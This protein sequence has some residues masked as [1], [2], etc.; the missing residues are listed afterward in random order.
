M[1]KIVN[2]SRTIVGVLFIFSG[3]VKANDPQGL[4]Y[5]MQEFFEVWASSGFFKNL[6]LQLHHNALLF[7]VIMIAAEIVLG[8][9]LLIAWKPKLTTWLLFLLTVF[10]TFLTAYVLFSGKIKACGCFGDCIPLTPKQ[11]FAKDIVLLVLVMILLFFQKYLQPLFKP[12]V[13]NIAVLASLAVAL[14]FQWYCLQYLPFKDCLPYKVGNDIKVQMQTPKDAVLPKYEYTFIYEKN[15]QRKQFSMNE[16]PDSTWKFVDREQVVVQEGKNYLPP[17]ADFALSDSSGK[18]V[19]DSILSISG[20]H[21]LL[22]VKE[23][24]KNREKWISSLKS[25]TEKLNNPNLLAVVTAQRMQVDEFLKASGVK[26]SETFSCDATAIKTASRANPVIF[27]LNG[28]VIAE[29][30]SWANFSSL[31][32]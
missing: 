23:L 9:A 25:F 2:I 27:T 18:D 21:Y 8:L 10:F 3:L 22:F 19:T 31:Q 4:A 29:K 24:P 26:Y 12:L 11:T 5:K 17:I 7:S 1:S 6:M 16:L 32:P 14:G 20:K 28:S 30:R 13:T 15:N